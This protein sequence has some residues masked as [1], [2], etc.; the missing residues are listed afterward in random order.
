MAR[1]CKLSIVVVS[2]N[3]RVFLDQALVSIQKALAGIESELFVVDNASTD[4]SPEW[5]SKKFPEIKLIRNRT[6]VGF[7]RANNQAIKKSRGRFICLINP[8]TLVQEDT[9]SV[10]LDFLQ[11]DPQVGAVGCKI[12]NPDGS[13][14]LACRRS[15]P[16]PWVA[17]SKISGLAALFPRSRL[18]GRYNLT[19]LDPDR[20]ERVDAISGSFMLVRSQTIKEVGLLD[21]S[22]FMYGEDLDWCYRIQQGGW[23]IYYVPTTQIIHFK[24]E[25]SKKSPFAQRRLFYEA[26]RLFV[27]K[28][29]SRGQALVP[30]WLLRVAIALRAG[31]AYLSQA[32]RIVALPLIDLVFLTLSL[33]LAIGLRFYPDYPY[34]SFLIVHLLYSCV[35]F[36]SLAAHGLY[37]RRR[38]SGSKAITAILLGWLVNGVLTYFIQVIAFSRAVLLYAGAMNIL[39][40][41]GWRAALANLS[42]KPIGILNAVLGKAVFFNRSVL[43]GDLDSIRHLVHRLQQHETA[44]LQ[45]YGIIPSNSSELDAEIEGVPILGRLRDLEEIVKREKINQIIFSTEKVSYHRILAIISGL[46]GR[47][48]TFSLVPHEMDVMIGKTS[49]DYLDHLPLVDIE[50]KLEET[51][52]RLNKRVFDLAIA[53]PLMVL[54]APAVFWLRFFVKRRMTTRT[55]VGQGGRPFSVQLFEGEG[56]LTALPLLFW[57]VRGRISLVGRELFSSTETVDALGQLIEPGLTGLEQIHPHP[58]L[59]KSEREYYYLYYLRNYSPAL[60]LQILGKSFARWMRN[61]KK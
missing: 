50:Y 38:F 20:I 22:F 46:A 18:F 41:A 60:D 32:M 34:R 27:V 13:L 45:I 11:A 58:D 17:F 55:V 2:Y 9:F 6:N 56:R 47:S 21:E 31:L 42:Q 49:I 29:F 24:G 48:I 25:S 57:V 19:Y 26:M 61:K 35:W 3:V 10:L 14:Q 37:G 53:T 44:S 5:V 39:F 52:Y 36:L 28:H 43:V 51:F 12:L 15:Y 59:S 30:S 54:S 33:A 16:T 8:D 4:G 40:L 7:A 1:N 23:L